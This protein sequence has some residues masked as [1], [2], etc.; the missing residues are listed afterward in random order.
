MHHITPI[1]I[2]LLVLF[3]IFRRTRRTIGFQKFVIGRMITR[4][5][6]LSIV[7][8]HGLLESHSVHL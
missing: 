2:V 4:M 1:F 3:S 7:S 6:L 5:T 8:G